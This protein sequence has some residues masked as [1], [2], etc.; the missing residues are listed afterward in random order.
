MES[1]NHPKFYAVEPIERFILDTSAVQSSLRKL[2]QKRVGFYYSRA[3]ASK[4]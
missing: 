1:L 3:K 4:G 2:A